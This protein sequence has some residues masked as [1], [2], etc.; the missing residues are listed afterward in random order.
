MALARHI[1]VVVVGAPLSVKRAVPPLRAGSSS[2][3]GVLGGEGVHVR[4]GGRR[5][6]RT[7]LAY[8]RR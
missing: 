8:R 2:R 4:R 3:G 1:I 6:P 7:G 5:R